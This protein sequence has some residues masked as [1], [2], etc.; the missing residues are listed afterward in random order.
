MRYSSVFSTGERRV[1]DKILA[2][3]TRPE[4]ILELEKAR[5]RFLMKSEADEAADCK[6]RTLVGARV[7]R[8]DAERYREDADRRGMSLYRYVTAAL[9]RMYQS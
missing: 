8:G 3:G 7:P 5:R 2:S 9:E 6:R 4:L 1:L